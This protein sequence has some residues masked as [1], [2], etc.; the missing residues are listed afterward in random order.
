MEY[1]K[2]IFEILCKEIGSDVKVQN[3]YDKKNEAKIDIYIAKNK[4]DFELSTYSTIGL[5]EYTIGMTDMNDRE[6]RVEFIGICSTDVDVFPN[7]LAS[8]AFNIINS[9]YTCKPGIVYPGVITPYL[10]ETDMKHIYFTSPFL[11]EGLQGLEMNHN[12]LAW[13]LAIP[14][15]DAEFKYIQH[16]GN[17]AF[18]E[19][20]EQRD[21]GFSDIYRN[22]VL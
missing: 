7:I 12:R 8:C 6:I 15:S 10:D 2:W 18:E 22:S 5:S 1:K 13:L 3:Y 17:E 14:I 20:L 9:K 4:P 11:W 21:V 16:N 19:L